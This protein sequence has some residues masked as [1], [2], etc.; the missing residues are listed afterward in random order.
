MKRTPVTIVREPLTDKQA[1]YLHDAAYGYL[2]GYYDEGEEEYPP[3]KMEE[4]K[5]YAWDTIAWEREFEPMARA[6]YFK[7]KK[8]V[9]AQI[10]RIIL[11]DHEFNAIVTDR[12]F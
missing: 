8:N 2:N 4:L 11:E 9:M 3:M 10:E 7:G 1:E 6:I 12:E 5:T